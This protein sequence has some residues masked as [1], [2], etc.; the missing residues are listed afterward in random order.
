MEVHQL[1]HI[2]AESLAVS[3]NRRDKHMN[4]NNLYKLKTVCCI[5][6]IHLS[7]YFISMRL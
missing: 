3:D 4:T 7:L 5:T 6:S 2:Q 1:V